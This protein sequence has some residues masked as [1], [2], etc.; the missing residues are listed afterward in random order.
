LDTGDGDSADDLEVLQS[1]ESYFNSDLPYGKLVILKSI[2]IK[3]SFREKGL[4]SAAIEEIKKYWTIF[5]VDYLALK[6]APMDL[7]LSTQERKH[8]I[9]KLV[10]FY[11]KFGF[12]K[13]NGQKDSEPIMVMDL[14]EN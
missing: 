1:M 12:I 11:E 14:N 8:Y 7:K 3:E 13:I 4:G 9:K 5:G 2:K 10:S 6:P